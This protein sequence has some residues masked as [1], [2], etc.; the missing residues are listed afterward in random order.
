MKVATRNRN[1]GTEWNDRQCYNEQGNQ[2]LASSREILEVERRLRAIEKVLGVARE[3]RKETKIMQMKYF[4]RRYT[5]IG[6][7]LELDISERTF[8]TEEGY[9]QVDC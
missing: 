6:I 9:N 7:A 2:G 4:E 1:C 5:D 3:R 8:T